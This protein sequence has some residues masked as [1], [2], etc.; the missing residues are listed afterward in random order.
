MKMK[1]SLRFITLVA[2][3]FLPSISWAEWTYGLEG[4]SILRDGNSATRIRAHASLNESPVSHYLYADWILSGDSSYELGY[5]PRYWFTKDVYGFGEGRL[6]IEDALSIDRD[7]LVL[8]GIGLSLLAN[9]KQQVVLEAGIG[10]QAIAYAEQT[11]LDE[12]NS[13]VGVLRGRAS[14]VL[15][16]L[17]KL[18]LDADVFTTDAF[19]ESRLEAGVS[20]RV[21]RGAIKLSYRVRRI[22]LDG[23]EAISETDTAVGFTLGF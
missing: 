12:V 10:Y 20:M 21:Q 1:K 8:G 14:Q 3:V 6:R 13:S 2:A 23:L 18:E 11:G 16:D 15:S 17:F 22:D 19:L 4:G 5:R 7:T 9:E